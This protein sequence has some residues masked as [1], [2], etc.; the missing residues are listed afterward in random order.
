MIASTARHGI[1]FVLHAQWN[2]ILRGTHRA[3][4][5][6]W[7]FLQHYSAHKFTQILEKNYGQVNTKSVPNIWLDHSEVF[8]ENIWIDL[9]YLNLPNQ[10]MIWQFPSQKR[11][12]FNRF[13]VLAV[14]LIR[15]NQIR[16]SIIRGRSGF[17]SCSECFPIVMSIN[18]AKI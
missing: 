8:S 3:F 9:I 4:V 18:H 1:T 16:S 17:H 13:E 11:P 5:G 15:S 10:T 6:P 7:L 12:Q 2:E 14:D